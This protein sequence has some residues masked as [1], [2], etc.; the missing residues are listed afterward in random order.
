MQNKNALLCIR[1]HQLFAHY[2]NAAIHY[3]VCYMT[4]EQENVLSQNR[5]RNYLEVI[6]EY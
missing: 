1:A 6:N 3:K 4:L 5:F 2:V